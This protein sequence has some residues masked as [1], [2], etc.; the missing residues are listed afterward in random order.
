MRGGAYRARLQR[1]VVDGH[2]SRKASHD[3]YSLPAGMDPANFDQTLLV[4]HLAT[5]SLVTGAGY[6]RTDEGYRMSQK[7]GGLQGVR[8]YGYSGY[9]YR[10]DGMAPNLNGEDDLNEL[11]LEVRSGDINLKDWA[12]QTRIGM[13]ALVVAM[14]FIDE[15]RGLAAK[16]PQDAGDAVLLAKSSCRLR[17][18]PDGSLDPQQTESFQTALDIQQRIAEFAMDSLPFYVELPSEYFVVAKE[19]YDYIDTL[20]QCI[21]DGEQ[22]HRLANKS[23]WAAKLAYITAKYERDQKCGVQRKILDKTARQQDMYYDYIDIVADGSGAPTIRHG[24]GYLLRDRDQTRLSVSAQDKQR[25]RYHAPKDTRAILR[26]HLLHNYSI[27]SCEWGRVA[28]E[29]P[30]GKHVAIRLSPDQTVFTE[31][32]R[33]LLGIA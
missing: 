26:S 10:I 30:R 4:A 15:A 13:T 7:N 11:R 2:G 21:R 31:E 23:D 3:N 24:A 16:V 12:I 25:A 29:T 9:M 20:K 22:V 1:R 8:G 6:V 5:R 27:T 33:D 28:L 18:Q 14:S 32:Q 17:V 19:Q